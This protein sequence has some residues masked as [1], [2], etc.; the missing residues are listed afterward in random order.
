MAVSTENPLTATSANCSLKLAPVSDDRRLPSPAYLVTSDGLFRVDASSTRRIEAPLPPPARADFVRHHGGPAATLWMTRDDALFVL[1]PADRKWRQVSAAPWPSWIDTLIVRSESDIWAFRLQQFAHYDGTQWSIWQTNQ[2][3]GAS[4]LAY[5]ATDDGV[6]VLADGKIWRVGVDGSSSQVPTA[7]EHS[8]MQVT[9]I[10]ATERRLVG[11]AYGGLCVRGDTWSC[12]TATPAQSPWDPG[13]P[14]LIDVGPSGLAAWS[15]R[16][17]SAIGD[18][19][20]MVDL[21]GIGDDGKPFTFTSAFFDGS[22]RIWVDVLNGFRVIDKHGAIVAEYRAGMLDGI[23]GSVGKIIIPGAG[24]KSLPAP[25]LRRTI[26]VA[27]RLTLDGTNHALGG[28]TVTVEIGGGVE[29]TATSDP[30]GA[31]LLREVPEGDY[32]VTVTPRENE[33]ACPRHSSTTGFRFR[34]AR[35]CPASK[36]GSGA[37]DVGAFSQCKQFIV[38][39]SR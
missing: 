25:K 39:P 9:R 4:A 29:R 13:P 32:E 20:C 21:E 1:G 38:P 5:V 22:D 30:S 7:V 15:G 37:C 24:P 18:G 28:A 31:F 35:D 3:F 6:W 34:T 19:T 16:S 2:V 12:G 11:S 8:T 36:L 14:F 26:D 33:T 23:N 27:G 17:L 10:F